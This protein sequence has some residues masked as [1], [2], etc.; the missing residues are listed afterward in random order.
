MLRAWPQSRDTAEDTWIKSSWFPWL[1]GS[2][3]ANY[4][5]QGCPSYH[6]VCIWPSSEQCTQLLLSQISCIPS[7]SKKCVLYEDLT[8]LG[9]I[10]LQQ[11]ILGCRFGLTLVRALLKHSNCSMHMN[12]QADINF[13]NFWFTH[14]MLVWN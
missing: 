11:Y 5:G 7:C 10:L 2:L 9:C 1:S 8:A 3:Q 13:C 12:T 6:K 14:Q 4:A